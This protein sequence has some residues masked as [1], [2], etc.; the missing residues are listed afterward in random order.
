MDIRSSEPRPH[1]EPEASAPSPRHGARTVLPLK[2]TVVVAFVAMAVPVL[3]VVIQ[4]NYRAS[5]TA[6]RNNAVTLIERFRRD[7]KQEIVGEFDSLRALVEPAAE[8]G[9]QT[10]AFFEDDRAL[11]YLFQTLKFRDTALNVYV[12]LTDG[13]FRQA[14][15]IQDPDVAIMGRL[16]P[17]GAEYAYRV[18]DPALGR[19]LLDRYIFLDEAENRLGMVARRSGY[20]PRQRAWYKAAVRKGATTITDPELFWAFGLVGFTVAKPYAVD[21][22]LRGVVAVDVTLDRFSAYLGQDPISDN[23]VSYLLDD[24]GRVLAAS[25]RAKTYGS[26]NEKV[27][28]PHITEIDNRLAARAF[29]EKPAAPEASF[30]IFDHDAESYIAGVSGFDEDFG[31][32][33]TLLTITPIADFTRAFHQKD[34]RMVAIGLGAVLVQLVVAYLIASFISAPL[35]RMARKVQ[36]IQSGQRSG[37]LPPVRSRVREVA[38]LSDAIDTLDAAIITRTKLAGLQQELQIA[39]DLQLSFL[40]SPMPPHPS[41]EVHGLMETARKVGGDFY[42]YFLIDERHL[43]VVVADVSGKGIAA[44]LFMA[45]TRTLLNAVAASARTPAEAITEVNDFLAAD[46]EQMMFVTVFYGVLDLESG[47]FTYVNAGHNPPFLARADGSPVFPLPRSGDP[48]IAVIEGFPFTQLRETLV[49]GDIVCLYTD[50]VTEAFAPDGTAYGEDRLGAAIAEHRTDPAAQLDE[51][52]RD[53]VLT[54]ERGAE[55]ADDLTCVTLRY[56]GHP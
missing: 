6:A 55:R 50:G 53:R 33:W 10:P 52:L 5:E 40:P 36:L 3:L 12:G 13:S 7:A 34:Q 38:L 9:K 24:E 22:T 27:T 31:K 14:R 1:R 43:G 37:D 25:D 17:E 15:R 44:A 32:P 21:G 51:T 20:D 4:I 48:A 35:Q 16:P 42:D 45:I 18:V 2:P 28:L 29:E 39:R 46:N 8:V 23:S 47:A 30:Y 54:F 26:D 11:P 56:H 19:P 49:P 41:F